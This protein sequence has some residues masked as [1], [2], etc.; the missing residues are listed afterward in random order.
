DMHH[1]TGGRLTGGLTICC[2]PNFGI[3]VSAFTTEKEVRNF[4]ATSDAAGNPVIARPFFDVVNMT[5]NAKAVSFP[6]AFAGNVNTIVA[7]QFWGGDF[8]L[9]LGT[10][11]N[12]WWSATLL[13][14]FKYL[15]FDEQT[16]IS[17]FSAVLPGGFAQVA[18]LPVTAPNGI[19][20]LDEFDTRNQFY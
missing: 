6:R 12:S 16:Q 17:Q 3:E 18:G 4:S 10:T 2:E 8:A 20:V 19:A 14:G 13:G 7:S 1:F 9:A 11:R 15:E 5:E